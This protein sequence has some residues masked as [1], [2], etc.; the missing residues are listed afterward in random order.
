[1]ECKCA[2]SIREKIAVNNNDDPVDVY[3]QNFAWLS[4]LV[5]L[6]RL[7]G[8]IKNGTYLDNTD[9]GN[10][11]WLMSILIENMDNEVKKMEKALVK[12]A[13]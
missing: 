4:G 3:M 1:M 12:A 6:I 9:A 10:V 2:V 5:S 11:G 8:E 13:A 7:L